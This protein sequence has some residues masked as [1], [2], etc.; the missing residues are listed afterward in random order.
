VHPFAGLVA[1]APP[2]A[3]RLLIN[4]E[5]VGEKRMLGPRGFDFG[6]S[7]DAFFEGD[8]DA[9]VHRLCELLGWESELHAALDAAR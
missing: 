8:C 6:S 2:T 1:E 4:R 3:H 5:R 7:T 9:A